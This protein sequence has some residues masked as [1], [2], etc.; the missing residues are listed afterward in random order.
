[1]SIDEYVLK[2]TAMA[3]VICEARIPLDDGELLLIALNGFDSSYDA[4]VTT[5]MTR[6]DDIIFASFQG[7]LR[8]FE[9]RGLKLV[10]QGLFIVANVIQIQ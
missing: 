8:E 1:M 2:L 9:T 3:E 6:V 10:N 7:L 5:H 4:F